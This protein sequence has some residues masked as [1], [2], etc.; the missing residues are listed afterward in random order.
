VCEREVG[1]EFLNWR[2]VQ[3]MK[4]LGDQRRKEQ[5]VGLKFLRAAQ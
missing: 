3:K 4:E 1:L 5:V 2:A